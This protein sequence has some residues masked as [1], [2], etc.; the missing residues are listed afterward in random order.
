MM[1]HVFAVKCILV[2]KHKFINDVFFRYITSFCPRNVYTRKQ[3]NL[4]VYRSDPIE[5]K[6]R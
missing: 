5:H 1:V 6:L 2:S 3:T 4:Q